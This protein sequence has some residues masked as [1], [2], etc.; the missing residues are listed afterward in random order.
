M[1]HKDTTAVKLTVPPEIWRI[2]L[3]SFGTRPRDLV[4]LWTGCRG[5]SQFFKHEIEEL[6]IAQCLP[7]T[8]LLFDLTTSQGFDRNSRIE[9]HDY[10]VQTRYSHVSVDRTSAFF[11][12]ESDNGTRLLQQMHN[13]GDSSAPS[14]H[15]NLW[16]PSDNV[17]LPGVFFQ[18]DGNVQVGWRELFA[19]ILAEEKYHCH[20]GWNPIEF[21]VG[22]PLSRKGIAL[23][24]FRHR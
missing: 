11:Q 20:T 13:G 22:Q 24:T 19:A 17:D 14:H 10:Q 12:A 9:F 4:E 6:C 2:V 8:S 23:I 21:Q 5:V 1:A 3:H 16:R 15:V 18:A 7:H